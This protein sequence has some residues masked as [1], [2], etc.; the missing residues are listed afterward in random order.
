MGWNGLE[1][2]VMDWFG[3]EHIGME[4]KGLQWVGIGW[5]KLKQI[6]MGEGNGLGR[7]GIGKMGQSELELVGIECKV[8]M[9]WN[10]LASAEVGWDGLEL[11]KMDLD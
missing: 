1:Y 8:A 5:N 3:S 10:R 6:L 2:S 9:S 4:Q 11:V 7:V